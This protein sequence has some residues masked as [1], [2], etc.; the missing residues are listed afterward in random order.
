M[1]FLLK[2]LFLILFY[3]KIIIASNFDMSRDPE[4]NEI[5]QEEKDEN[6]DSGEKKD[7][8]K[9]ESKETEPKE[10]RIK[11]IEFDYDNNKFNFGAFWHNELLMGK[12]LNFLNDNLLD[13]REFYI[14]HVLDFFASYT[15]TQDPFKEPIIR[16]EYGIRNRAI[17]ATANVTQTFL[18]LS[19]TNNVDD[20]AIP[21]HNHSIFFSIFW[22]RKL[23][24]ELDLTQLLGLPFCKRHTLTVG[25]FP[26]ELGHAI[27]L[28]SLYLF[29]APALS[30]YNDVSIDQYSFGFKL[31]GDLAPNF[32]SYDLYG[33]IFENF[34]T[35][36]E[37]TNQ[38]SRRRQFGHCADQALGF[39]NINYLVAG[40]LKY[41][42]FGDKLTNHKIYFEPYI[43]YN[44]NPTLTLTSPFEG[45]L[46]YATV[47]LSLDFSISNHE[48]S[49]ET[50]KNLGSIT[51]VGIDRN[52]PTFVNASGFEAIVNDQVI[53]TNTNLPA[54]VT[55]QNQQ[56]IDCKIQA[57]SQNGK[58]ISSTLRNS[59]IRFRNP[60]WI[61]LHGSFF[62][63]EYRYTIIQDTLKISGLC[64]FFSGDAFNEFIQ[65]PAPIID[66]N[67]FIG[68]NETYTGN[69][70]TSILFRGY[71]FFTN[72]FNINFNG[73]IFVPPNS[74]LT[75]L[76]MTGCSLDFK[77]NRKCRNWHIF[78]NVLFYWQDDTDDWILL[79]SE[80][81][82]PCPVFDPYL[83]MECNVVI[84][85]DFHKDFRIFTIG[86]LFIP[87]TQFR[88]RRNRP[89][90]IAQEVFVENK[91]N[92][93]AFNPR[94]PLI[95]S[96]ISYII[97]VG[98]QY[99]F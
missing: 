33:T 7:E 71:G 82:A 21:D 17:W 22:V 46:N 62:M 27:S 19:E 55:E 2:Y 77:T 93:V 48:F 40:R 51:A 1:F 74:G 36:F 90:S 35:S 31:S 39:G 38:P 49:F 66:F 97:N 20:I 34:A 72:T 89:T 79:P 12:N 32:L 10:Y 16:V 3:S 84:E 25:A 95:G 23:W 50:G 91:F 26:F 59:P 86:A 70:V 47:G 24:I 15:F 99:T 92:Q 44:Y 53:N 30:Y 45:K 43:L 37:F 57:Q 54:L 68:I 56:L 94:E 6:G 98:L 96:D 85:Y 29:T 28:G 76:L 52:K 11:H 42:M 9:D 81:R 75:N 87:G 5:K 60:V 78:P 69:F 65:N 73:N 58:L 80:K 8:N 14:Q 13:D 88:Q 64:A 83:G 61:K 18:T 4:E 67:G 41:F 63:T